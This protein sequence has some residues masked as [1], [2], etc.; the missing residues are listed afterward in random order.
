MRDEQKVDCGALSLSSVLVHHFVVVV[1]GGEQ[2]VCREARRTLPAPAGP[3]TM[4]PY[5]L[6]LA[7]SGGALGSDWIY[8]LKRRRSRE[9]GL[10]AKGKHCL[11]TLE[12]SSP[13]QTDGDVS[14]TTRGSFSLGRHGPLSYQFPRAPVQI[15]IQSD[16]ALPPSATSPSSEHSTAM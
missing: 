2:P 8:V 4:T 12:I 5:L 11:C 1:H 3:M 7:V 16:S 6:I 9:F 14:P 13:L 10:E 15:F